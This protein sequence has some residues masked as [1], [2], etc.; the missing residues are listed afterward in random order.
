MAVRDRPR[1]KSATRNTATSTSVSVTASPMRAPREEGMKADTPRILRAGSLEK[2]GEPR[3]LPTLSL[4]LH[5]A[6]PAC[7]CASLKALGLWAWADPTWRS[8]Q[9]RAV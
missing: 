1:L 3:L 7:Q 8:R 4:A 5:V 6:A 9:A 2:E